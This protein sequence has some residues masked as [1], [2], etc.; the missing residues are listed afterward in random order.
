MEEVEHLRKRLLFQCQHR[1]TKELDLVLGPFAKA[2]LNDLSADELL[3]LSVFLTEPDPNIYDWLTG[4]EPLPERLQSPVTARLV[5][6]GSARLNP[7]TE[8]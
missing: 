2:H 1:G 8:E 3:I 7:G 6:F 4:R 5:A